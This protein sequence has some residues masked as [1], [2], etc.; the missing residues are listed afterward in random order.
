MAHHRSPDS[1]LDEL[2]SF[3]QFR[4]PTQVTAFG[5]GLVTRTYEII[6]G[7]RR[8]SASVLVLPNGQ[9]EQFIVQATGS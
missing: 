6:A 2:R 9:I 5:D 4:T 7:D 1:L 8:L 3:G